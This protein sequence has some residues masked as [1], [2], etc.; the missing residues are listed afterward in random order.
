MVYFNVP[1]VD[2]SEEIQINGRSIFKDTEHM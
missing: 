2:V 1:G